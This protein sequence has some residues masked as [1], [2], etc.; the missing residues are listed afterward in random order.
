MARSAK[1]LDMKSRI[2][3]ITHV[4]FIPRQTSRNS[5]GELITKLYDI[6]ENFVVPIETISHRSDSESGSDKLLN[7][8]SKKKVAGHIV[9]VP[10]LLDR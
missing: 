5:H 2:L 4:C 3:Q 1:I 9:N 6:R 8:T 7:V 10:L